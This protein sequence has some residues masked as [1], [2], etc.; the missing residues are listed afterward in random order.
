M[1]KGT[2]EKKDIPKVAESERKRE[3]HRCW[4][5]LDKKEIEIFG[6]NLVID[7]CPKCKGIWLDKNELNKLLK[8][9]KLSAYLTKHIGTKSRSP[10]VCPRCGMTM[11]IEKADDIDVDV[12]L[13]CGG[14][15]LDQGELESLKTKSEQGFKGDPDAKTEE[16]FEEWLYNARNSKFHRFLKKITR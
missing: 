3:C 12:C 15:W 16:L 7:V 11:D 4:I 6:P 10:M 9:R 2:M 14:V 13:S 1:E 8:D 5:D